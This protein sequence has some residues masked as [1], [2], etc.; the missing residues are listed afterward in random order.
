MPETDDAAAQLSSL[1][2]TADFE[3][4]RR[5]EQDLVA[6]RRNAPAIAAPPPPP[7]PPPP[8]A[9]EPA[10]GRVTASQPAAPP[11]SDLMRREIEAAAAACDRLAASPAAR[12]GASGGVGSG[13]STQTLHDETL[14][15]QAGARARARLMAL[16]IDPF[17]AETAAEDGESSSVEAKDGGSSPAEA[18]DGA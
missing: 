8:R 16:G 15:L 6:L 1:D 14:A 11:R 7:P 13:A 17:A 3:L 5:L 18:K 9:E 12:G 10:H 4:L 2:L